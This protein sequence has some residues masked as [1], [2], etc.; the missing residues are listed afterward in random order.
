M[1]PYSGEVMFACPSACYMPKTIQQI[2]M[3][4]YIVNLH[5]TLI[6]IFHFSLCMMYTYEAQIKLC[7][8]LTHC[9]LMMIP[10]C[11]SSN[12]YLTNLNRQFTDCVTFAAFELDGV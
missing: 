3:K 1:H 8:I 11:G 2:F 6:N 9:V 12:S 5:Q 4:F 7:L 10:N